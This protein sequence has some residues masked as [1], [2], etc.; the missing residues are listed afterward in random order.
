M[1]LTK[2]SSFFIALFFVLCSYVV[3]LPQEGIDNEVLGDLRETILDDRYRPYVKRDFSFFSADSTDTLY[4]NFGR[5]MAVR[6]SKTGAHYKS[7]S[8]LLTRMTLFLEATGS[9]KTLTD[10]VCIYMTNSNSDTVWNSPAR[11][12][13]GPFCIAGEDCTASTI[14]T[15]AAQGA[16]QLNLAAA[17]AAGAAS[18]AREF[19]YQYKWLHV[20]K[21]VYGQ[22]AAAGSGLDTVGGN[23]GVKV[24]FRTIDF[25][26][27]VI[28]KANSETD[29]LVYFQI[30]PYLFNAS[31]VDT[32]AMLSIRLEGYK[33]DVK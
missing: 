2:F 24:L 1:Y 33:I 12:V 9:L 18:N 26:P 8:Y 10:T 6:P 15:T 4:G 30:K 20:F 11:L 25:I 32:V 23:A 7:N 21:N 16:A 19:S 31:G 29:S 13:W 3:S 14:G 5:Y 28:Y 27:P 17:S 22:H